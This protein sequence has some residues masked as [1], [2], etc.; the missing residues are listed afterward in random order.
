MEYSALWN[1][2]SDNFQIKLYFWILLFYEIEVI[3][4]LISAPNYILQEL[5]HKLEKF[6]RLL[7]LNQQHFL[8]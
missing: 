5:L 3:T 6:S 8:S 7:K 4:A 2:V 1:F